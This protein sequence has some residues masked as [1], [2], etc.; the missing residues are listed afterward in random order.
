MLTKENASKQELPGQRTPPVPGGGESTL[1][2][3]VLGLTSE[4]APC[5]CTGLADVW[6]CKGTAGG[7]GGKGGLGSSKYLQGK[8]DKS[9][10]LTI[11]IWALLA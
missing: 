7:V 10:A 11:V 8:E 5:P 2:P 3:C 6:H 1:M 4:G 9:A